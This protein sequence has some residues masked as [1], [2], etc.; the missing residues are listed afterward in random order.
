M[1]GMPKI[2]AGSYPLGW[3]EFTEWKAVTTG[4]VVEPSFV[5]GE[6]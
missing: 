6:K 4:E 3:Q 1:L 2:D 5:A